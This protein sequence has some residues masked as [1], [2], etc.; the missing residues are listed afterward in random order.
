MIIPLAA[1]LGNEVST[2]GAVALAG[3]HR[4]I[5]I[6]SRT[7]AGKSLSL[8]PLDHHRSLFITDAS[9][10]ILC[11]QY[12]VLYLACVSMSFVDESR[13]IIQPSVQVTDDIHHIVTG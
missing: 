5:F 1:A 11:C 4:S 12:C 9:N 8:P 6:Q 13:A 7:T 10:D 3:R 2:E